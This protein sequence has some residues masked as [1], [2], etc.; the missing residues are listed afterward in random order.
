MLLSRGITLSF[1]FVSC[2]MKTA[3]SPCSSTGDTR[4]RDVK[5]GPATLKAACQVVNNTRKP[6][7]KSRSVSHQLC[8]PAPNGPPLYASRFSPKMRL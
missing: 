8:E 6:G 3:I 4:H 5:E 7:F 2:A 1:S